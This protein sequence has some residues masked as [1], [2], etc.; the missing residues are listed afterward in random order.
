M[1]KISSGESISS[2]FN[3]DRPDVLDLSDNIVSPDKDINYPVGENPTMSENSKKVIEVFVQN[4]IGNRWRAQ[5][6]CREVNTNVFYPLKYDDTETP[7]KI[8][9][10]CAVRQECLEEAIRNREKEGIWG[11]MTYKERRAYVKSR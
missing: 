3:V 8:C 9:A 1:T 5:A 4:L 7:K 10:V 2:E 6:S 11:G